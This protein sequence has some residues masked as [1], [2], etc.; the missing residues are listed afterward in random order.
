MFA[1]RFVSSKSRGASLKQIGKMSHD[2]KKRR[3][4]KTTSDVAYWFTEK[5]KF[6]NGKSHFKKSHNAENCKRWDPLGFLKIQ[7]VAKCQNIEGGPFRDVTKLSNKK[8]KMRIL[9]ICKRGG[10]LW[11]LLTSIL[12]QNI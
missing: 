10:A 5:I 9:N 4:K 6:E 1:K 7:F 8:R 3:S 12:L 2:A 11:N